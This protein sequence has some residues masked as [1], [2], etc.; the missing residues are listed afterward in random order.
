M[1]NGDQTKHPVLP[2]LHDVRALLLVVCTHREHADN[3]PLA[4]SSRLSRPLSSLPLSLSLFREFAIHCFLA[5]AETDKTAPPK[6]GAGMIEAR[7]H[8]LDGRTTLPKSPPYYTDRRRRGTPRTL[9][10]HTRT[11]PRVGR[12]IKA[13]GTCVK[14]RRARSVQSH[15]LWETQYAIIAH[16]DAWGDRSHPRMLVWDR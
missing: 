9:S 14:T 10:T 8:S 3:L 4:P 1:Q 12:I 6:G 2:V 16:Y 15:R 7:P 11:K 13:P 5:L